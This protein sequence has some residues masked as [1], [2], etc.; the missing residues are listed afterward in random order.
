MGIHVTRYKTENGKTKK[1]KKEK[2]ASLKGASKDGAAGFAHGA[3]PDANN[4]NNKP[5]V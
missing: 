4:K 3:S 5:G 1:V 2:D